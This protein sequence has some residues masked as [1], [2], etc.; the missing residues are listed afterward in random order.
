MSLAF[1]VVEPQPCRCDLCPSGQCTIGGRMPAPPERPGTDAEWS[2]WN[3]AV[4]EWFAVRDYKRGERKRW[5]LATLTAHLNNGGAVEETWP[6]GKGTTTWSV[7][8]PFFINLKPDE[9][10]AYL[11]DHL[12]NRHNGFGT[13]LRFLA[14]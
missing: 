2:A 4:D 10:A 7:A 6:S 12:L 9:V 8:R 5:A 1:V 11:A 13:Q 14:W 3:K